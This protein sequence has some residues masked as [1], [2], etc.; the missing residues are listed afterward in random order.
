MEQLPSRHRVQA[1]VAASTF[2]QEGRFVFAFEPA[3]ARQVPA[4]A[5]RDGVRQRR[6]L[7]GG[8]GAGAMQARLALR[9]L[10]VLIHAVEQAQRQRPAIGA[11]PG[12]ARR[13]P[14]QGRLHR[15]A[16]AITPSHRRFP[17]AGSDIAATWVG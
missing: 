8:R 2:G 4:H 9:L 14:V 13:A 11:R 16:R 15:V 7:R 5:M 6:Q 12:A 3:V 1:I 10:D 17:K